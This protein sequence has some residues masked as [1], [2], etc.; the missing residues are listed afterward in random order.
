MNAS[1]LIKRFEGFRTT[2]YW[3]VNAYR[4]GYGSDTVTMADGRVVPVQ[5]GM[6]VT[7]EDAQRDLERRISSEFMPRAIAKVGQDAWDHLSEP[8]RASLLSVTYNYGTLPDSVA[9]RVAAGD[10]AGAATAIGD[11]GSHNG[12]VN[13]DRRAAEA[14]IFAGQ[15]LPSGALPSDPQARGMAQPPQNALASQ[16]AAQQ[17]AFAP[18]IA[19]LDPAQFMRQRNALAPVQNMYERRNYLGTA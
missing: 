11:L 13:A 3:D 10:F 8:Q 15:G 9:S 14:R 19:Q 2:P 16:P 17:N 4:T 5:Q 18:Q 12:G 7:P 6:T 1:E